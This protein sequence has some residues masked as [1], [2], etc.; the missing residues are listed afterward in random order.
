MKVD[1]GN[2]IQPN[3]TQ[4]SKS[5]KTQTPSRSFADV[6]NRTAQANPSD[7]VFATAPTQQILPRIV[8]PSTNEIYSA[9]ERV[10]DAMERYQQLLSDSNADLR[11]VYPVVQQLKDEV[12][13]LEPLMGQMAEEIPM[14][15]IA[16]EALLVA[17][18]E[19]ARFNG[20]VYVD[21]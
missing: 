12:V 13:N 7:K 5:K 10:V 20:G 9:T 14:K 2:N 11:T 8:N 19:I 16:R 4:A 21:A 6:L 15:Q 3:L 17:S 1:N 18:K